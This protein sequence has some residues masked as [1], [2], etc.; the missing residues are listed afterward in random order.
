MG[1]RY[2]INL[3]RFADTT[4][5]EIRT[6]D[7]ALFAEMQTRVLGRARAYLRTSFPRMSPALRAQLTNAD[8]PLTDWPRDRNPREVII[9][10]LAARNVAPE[11]R[12]EATQVLTDLE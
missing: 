2:L 10:T 11:L 1:S 6:R 3:H 9:Q 5:N 7:P 4:P 8:L 12:A